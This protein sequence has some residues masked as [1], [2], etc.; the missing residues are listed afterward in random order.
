MKKLIAT[1][2]SSLSLVAIGVFSAPKPVQAAYEDAWE[3]TCQWECGEA[4]FES[5]YG[6]YTVNGYAAEYHEELPSSETEASTWAYS[7]YWQPAGCENFS[8]SFSQTVC[9]DTAYLRGV[10]GWQEIADRYWGQGDDE[11][12]CAVMRDRAFLHN[13][14]SAYSDGWINRDESLMA[15]GG[16]CQ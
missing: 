11:L 14:G 7:D 15:E 3:F 9:F 13:D 6:G 16:G 12:A 10:G 8:S 2:L 5:E 4:N 1:V